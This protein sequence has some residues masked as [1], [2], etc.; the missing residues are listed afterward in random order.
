[1]K[2][3][4]NQEDLVFTPS[5]NVIGSI[6][7]DVN[8]VMFPEKKWNDFPFILFGWWWDGLMKLNT[9]SSAKFIFMDG[10]FEFILEKKSQCSRQIVYITLLDSGKVVDLKTPE[11][12]LK[13]FKGS[14]HDTAKQMV[15]AAH[16]KKWE[17][18]DIKGL[19]IRVNGFDSKYKF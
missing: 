16:S 15:A 3:Y 4:V 19:N 10:D 1:M 7:L 2:V 5:G 8:G 13:S 14:F 6:Y 11:I 18:S 17:N 9:T 12:S